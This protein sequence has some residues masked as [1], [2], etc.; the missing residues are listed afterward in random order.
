MFRKS[1]SEIM[2]I[3]LLISIFTFALN[4]QPAKAIGTIYIRADG[5]IEPPT[6]PVSTLDNTTYSFTGNVTGMIVVERDNIVVDGA[7][8]SLQGET[9]T[10]ASGVGMT[11]LGRTNV[12]VQN[13]QIEAFGGAIRIEISSDITISANNITMCLYGI[14]VEGRN[15]DGGGPSANNR[16]VRNNI[17]YVP[18]NGY[19][20]MLDRCF[21]NT[22]LQNEVRPL[23]RANPADSVGIALYNSVNNSVAENSIRSNGEGINLVDSSLNNI[24]DNN[25]WDN[26]FGI[27]LE[28][29]QFNLLI[30]NKVAMGVWH[31]EYGEEILVGY[32]VTIRYPNDSNMLRNNNISGHK[33]NFGIEDAYYS[34]SYFQDIDSSNT[35]DGKPI[36]YWVNKEGGQIPSDAGYVA[37]ANSSGIRVE[38][39]D[40]RNNYQGILL[41]NSKNTKVEHNNVLNNHVGVQLD[42]S[43]NNTVYENNVT[44]ND[45]GVYLTDS[46]DNAISGNNITAN[47]DYGIWLSSSSGNTLIGNE[48]TA[49][50]WDGIRLESSSNNTLFGNNVAN[51]GNGI[52]LTE[53]SCNN[54]LS[55]NNVTTSDGDGIVLYSSQNTLSDNNIAANKGYG[56]GLYAFS[57]DNILF[58]NNVARNRDGILLDVWTGNNVLSGNNVTTNDEY[59]IWLYSSFNNTLSGNNITAN[60]IYGIWLYSS[61]QN[62]V[63]YHNNF[64]SNSQLVYIQLSGYANS[65]DDGYLSGGNYWSD[66]T[67][68]D[69]FSG[70]YQN[71]TG[72]D[73]IGDTQYVID[74]N[75]T[76]HYP[77]MN[78]YTPQHDVAIMNVSPFKTV[79]GLGYSLNMSV[80]AANQGD[81]PETFNVTAYYGNGT[82]TPEEWNVFWHMGD[83]NRD[84]YINQADND[85]IDANYGRTVPPADSRADIA[86]PYGVV[87]LSDLV[88][89]ALHEGYEIWKYFL[90]VISAETIVDLA[91]GDSAALMFTWNTT[92]VAYGNYTMTAVADPVANETNTADNNC[93]C[94]IPVHVGVPGDISGPTLGVYD[95]KCDMRDV[96]YLIIRFNS[97]PSSANWNANADINND[98]TVNMRDISIAILNFN[99]HE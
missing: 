38:G 32:G 3:L 54:T 69:L 61:S 79:V 75:N 45:Y 74:E 2:L 59:G 56:V 18:Y 93:T 68:V 15:P 43:I 46:S 70:L 29:S 94:N 58:G 90:P 5:S 41:A 95:G 52:Y 37:V 82:F 6:T 57:D 42:S 72:S 23:R 12:T 53:G 1:V 51:N 9:N 35:V 14:R 8:H 77:L 44:D 84:G 26:F 39:L 71:E 22:I 27:L 65:W 63:F 98:A 60:K 76:D 55:G 28:G 34:L 67:G 33:F 96:S 36:Y 92:G 73:G 21:N 30:G 66:Y 20:I 24:A 87:G 85:I 83:C 49:N 62:N 19:G 91:G 4:I 80:T 97:K 16:I 81:Y 13:T 40:L 10:S 88:T 47:N 50:S 99:K 7:G 25:L 11:L 86:P 78:P 64:V 89:Y 48:V 31:D 17:T